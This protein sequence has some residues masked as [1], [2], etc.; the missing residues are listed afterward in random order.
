M[1]A[2]NPRLVGYDE[3]LYSVRTFF[4][5]LSASIGDKDDALKAWYDDECENLDDLTEEEIE[6]K[7]LFII[8]TTLDDFKSSFI[9]YGFEMVDLSISELDATF[10][11]S[12]SIFAENDDTYIAIAEGSE[13]HHLGFGFI[14]KFEYEDIREELMIHTQ[15]IKEYKHRLERFKKSNNI[16]MSN[17]FKVYDGYIS[18]R[19]SAWTSNKLEKTENYL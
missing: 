2:G 8:Q 13:Y 3:N 7:W 19:C 16:V 12:A 15:S 6:S 5:D 18:E 10:R 4:I 1:G 9:E 14:P 11:G 17:I